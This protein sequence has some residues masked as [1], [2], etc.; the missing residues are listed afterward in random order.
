MVIVKTQVSSTFAF[1]FVPATYIFDQRLI[2]FPDDNYETFSVLQS[3]F[4]EI[5]ADRYAATLKNDMSYTPKDCFETFPFPIIKINLRSTGDDYHEFRKG[6]MRKNS[7]GLTATTEPPDPF[8]FNCGN[9][10]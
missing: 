7:Q 2:V 6:I 4:H 1:H 3:T 9:S 10:K 5:W 8:S